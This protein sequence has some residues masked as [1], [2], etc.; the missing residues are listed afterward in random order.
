MTVLCWRIDFLTKDRR[1]RGLTSCS[2]SVCDV[3]RNAEPRHQLIPRGAS[4]S[5]EQKEMLPTCREKC[6]RARKK[7]GF[8]HELERTPPQRLKSN[9]CGSS[10]FPDAAPISRGSPKVFSDFSYSLQ[11]PFPL[12]GT[13]TTSFDSLDRLLPS[14]ILEKSK[15]IAPRLCW[16]CQVPA[17]GTLS[18]RSGAWLT[19]RWMPE[20][21]SDAT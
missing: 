11:P 13:P 7:S 20:D 15:L 14:F 5:K 9:Q 8:L 6:S 18:R 12:R 3:S 4:T 21:L 16:V 1:F 10:V 2:Q 17:W 19:W